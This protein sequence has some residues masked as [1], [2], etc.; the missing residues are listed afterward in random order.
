[1]IYTKQNEVGEPMAVIINPYTIPS[2]FAGALSLSLGIYAMYKNP[3]ERSTQIFFII[4]VGCSLWSLTPLL[5]QASNR[6]ADALLWAKLSNTGLLIIP[7]ALFH[8]TFLFQ[9]KGPIKISKIITIISIYILAIIMIILLLSTNLFFT[10]GED[11]LIDGD[12]ELSRSRGKGKYIED[13]YFEMTEEELEKF[14]FIDINNDEYYSFENKTSEPIMYNNTIIIGYPTNGTWV[15]LNSSIYYHFIWYVD[16]N[17][18]GAFDIGEP[19][20]LE[21]GD[22]DQNLRYN[23]FQGPLYW[24]L[25]IFFF[26]FIIAS[27]LNLLFFYRKAEN[28]D[29]KKSV[30]YLILGLT[31]VIIFILLQWVLAFVLPSAVIFLDNA[32]ALVI[33]VFFTVAVLKYNIV[34]IKLIIRKSMFYSLASLIVVFCFVLVEEG[35]EFLFSELAFSGSILSGVI[36]AFVALI[37]FSIVKRTLRHQIDR[38]FPSVRYMDKEYQNR[39]AAY[40]ATLFAMLAD[41]I[42]SGKESSAI[43]ILREKLEIKPD[44]HDQLMKDIRSEMKIKP[45]AI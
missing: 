13:L 38:L 30:I 33:S 20:Y 3:K 35:M 41:G 17:Q 14:Y 8:F 31:A 27:V 29:I 34:D 4:M 28:K 36:A 25:I 39:I 15:Q 5:V 9:R 22:G 18:S 10:M 37:T 45:T 1:M 26:G 42:I 40:K 23:Y 43:D 16:E 24:L 7:I 2:F 19:I 44:E 6:V 11:I 21:N 32:I 12:G